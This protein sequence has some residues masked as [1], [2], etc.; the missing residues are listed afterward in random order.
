MDRHHTIAALANGTGYLIILY[1]VNGA[2]TTV[3]GRTASRRVRR[4]AAFFGSSANVA[5]NSYEFDYYNACGD[6]WRHAAYPHPNI[7]STG[8]ISDCP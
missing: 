6:H 3:I 1:D 5:D 2:F 8:F 7:V 4:A